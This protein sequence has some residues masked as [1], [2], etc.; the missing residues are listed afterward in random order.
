MHHRSQQPALLFGSITVATFILYVLTAFPTVAG[1]D[2]GELVMA[3]ASSGVPHPPGYPLFALLGKFASVFPLGELAWRLNI[4]N[5]L[6]GAC[7][8]GI[9]GLA[10]ADWIGDRAGSRSGAITAAGLYAVSPLIWSYSTHA[11]VFTLNQLLV[12]ALLLCAVRY[13][14]TGNRHWALGGA[15]IFGLGLAN[16]HTMIFVGLPLAL[17]VVAREPAIW[18]RSRALVGLITAFAAG[19]VPYLYLPLASIRPAPITW[20]DQTTLQGFISHLTRSDYGTFRLASAEYSHSQGFLDQLQ[21][22]AW[23]QIGELWYAGIVLV[24]AGIWATF[25][26]RQMRWLGIWLLVSFAL[27]V[28]VFH[29]LANLPTD[30]P[31]FHEVQRRFWQMPHML[32]CIWAGLGLAML[33]AWIQAPGS[34]SLTGHLQRLVPVL[35]LM[36]WIVPAAVYFTAQDRSQSREFFAYGQSFLEPLPD[37]AVLLVRGDLIINATQ[38]VQIAGDIRPDVRIVDLERLTYPWMQRVVRQHLPG[39]HLPGERL[40]LHLQGGYSLNELIEAN[41]MTGRIFMAGDLKPEE[42]SVA[43]SFRLLPLGMAREL[44]PASEPLD[45][46]RWQTQSLAALPDFELPPARLRPAGSWSQIVWQDYWEAHHRHG[47]TLLE[48]GIHG[49]DPDLLTQAAGFLEQL[50][51]RNPDIH[52]LVYRNLGLAWARLLPFDPTAATGMRRAWET[53]LERA[54]DDDPAIDIIRAAL[55]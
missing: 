23:F 3:T 33:A 19:L 24:M 8:A 5:A 50:V 49:N 21:A 35:A 28:C 43:Q 20:G 11:E 10:V 37:H 9:L 27:Y 7:A 51:S 2:S 13:A 52:P 26:T 55:Q 34:Q 15:L 29:W 41:T 40:G 1:G 30:N 47:V 16:H 46:A 53:Y 32:T 22:Y 48:L 14:H 42:Q 6:F 25:R 45:A 54:E 39:I 18:L 12:A 44:V 17:I 31:L 4:L 38:Y 36:I